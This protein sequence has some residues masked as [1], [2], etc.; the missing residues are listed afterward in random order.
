MEK[1][2]HLFILDSC[3]VGLEPFDETFGLEGQLEEE[4]QFSDDV[5]LEFILDEA[6]KDGDLVF[7]N[8]ACQYG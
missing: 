2:V 1:F 4:E 8:S 7:G 6:V 3:E 5:A